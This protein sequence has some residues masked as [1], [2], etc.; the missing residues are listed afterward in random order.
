LK[1]RFFDPYHIRFRVFPVWSD[2]LFIYLFLFSSS[3]RRTKMRMTDTVR[4]TRNIRKL[5]MLMWSSSGNIKWK[6]GNECTQIAALLQI[7]LENGREPVDPLCWKNNIFETHTKTRKST[8][9]AKKYEKL[10][11]IQDTIIH[12]KVSKNSENP[13]KKFIKKNSKKFKN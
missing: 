3:C 11:K 4:C 10:R 2:F 6:P 7:M 1:L 9:N 12:T 5:K 8:K 13:S